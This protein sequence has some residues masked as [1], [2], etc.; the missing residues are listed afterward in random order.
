MKQLPDSSVAMWEKIAKRQKT[1]SGW[2]ATIPGEYMPDD[3]PFVA[4]LQGDKMTASMVEQFYTAVKGA[5]NARQERKEAEADRRALA[6]GDGGRRPDRNERPG[7]DA[8]PSEAAAPETQEGVE[9]YLKSQ[10]SRLAKFA[11]GYVL[12]RDELLQRI[13]EIERR[14]ADVRLKLKKFETA[15]TAIGEL[16]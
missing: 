6:E 7:N 16:T 3:K 2:K 12:E 11:A 13:A 1:P 14:E 5:Y 8:P 10:I 9:E 4:V 15:L